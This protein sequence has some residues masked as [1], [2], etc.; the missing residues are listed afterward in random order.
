MT[1][2]TSIPRVRIRSTLSMSLH[3]CN[4]SLIFCTSSGTTAVATI[5]VPPSF[6]DDELTTETA[7]G[8]L[9]DH[10]A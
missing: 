10:I 7:L 9:Q 1:I 5:I 4:M 3:F 6:S 2:I 8:P